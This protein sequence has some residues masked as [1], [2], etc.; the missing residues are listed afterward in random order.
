[1]HLPHIIYIIADKPKRKKDPS[2]LTNF[3]YISIITS[4]RRPVNMLIGKTLTLVILF[5]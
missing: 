3:K 2:L 4:E 1:M 5:Q